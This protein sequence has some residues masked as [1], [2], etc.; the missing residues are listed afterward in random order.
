MR[1]SDDHSQGIRRIVAEHAGAKAEV[2]LF[3]SRIDDA[4][5]GGDVDLLVTLPEPV[6]NPAMLAARLSARTT[7]L[8]EGRDVD[9]VLSAPNLRRTTVH[10][11]ADR[12]GH[13]L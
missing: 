13:T 2:K 8:M 4:R 1:L 5:R 6:A 3:G 7:R 10:E 12:E 11:T 9:V